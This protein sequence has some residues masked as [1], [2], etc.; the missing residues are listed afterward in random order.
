[1]ILQITASQLGV[2][3]LAMSLGSII[4]LPIAGKIAQRLG[5]AMTVRIGV[6]FSLLGMSIAAF[7]IQ[8]AANIAFPMVGLFLLGIGIGL[9]DVSQN[10][11]AAF[12][13]QQQKRPIMPWFHAAFSAGTVVGAALS[14]LAI[15]LGLD[16]QWQLP[17]IAIIC[18]MTVVFQTKYFLPDAT[19][20]PE[21]TVITQR[22]AKSAWLEPRTILIGLL[23]LVAA[24][25]EG[26][27]ND[28]LSLAFVEGYDV[29]TSVGVAGFAVF[30]AAMTGGRLI[31]PSL[32]AAWGRVRILQILFAAACIGSLLVGFGGLVGA[33]IGA[34]VWGFGA[35]LGFPVGISA[36]ADDPARAALR[37]SVVS[38]M[39][40]TAFIA[41]PPLIGIVSDQFG[42]LN[43]LVIVGI[44]SVLAF[45]L[46]PVTRPTKEIAPGN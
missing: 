40:Y 30:L 13:E 16:V 12:I 45:F 35:S 10:L 1:M 34:A 4:G 27:A 11:E 18:A 32:L 7:S 42:L 23:V 37:I 9:W 33:F 25:T 44:G 3:L 2:M 21:A 28:W 8:P 15:T 19:P 41:G 26:S 24:F 36:A 29:P 31:G 5:T 20:E 38:T 6:L 22:P 43:S 46:A 17:I 14:F 39:G